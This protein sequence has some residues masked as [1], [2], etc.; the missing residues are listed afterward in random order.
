MFQFI[1]KW[2]QNC[3]NTVV[4]MLVV[5][6]YSPSYIWEQSTYPLSAMLMSFFT[7]QFS[8]TSSWVASG[9]KVTLKVKDF[10]CTELSIWRIVKIRYQCR[11]NFFRIYISICIRARC[12]IS[13]YLFSLYNKISV[14]R[15]D[16]DSTCH[17]QPPIHHKYPVDYKKQQS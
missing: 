15:I 7:P 11:N 10:V 14:R 9:S 4:L 1:F 17:Q 8:N 13:P 3:P 16:I 5:Y 12:I 6:V 2:K